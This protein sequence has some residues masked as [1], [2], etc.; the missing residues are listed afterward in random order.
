VWYGIKQLGLKDV[1][2]RDKFI[3]EKYIRASVQERRDLLSA[4]L[5]CDGCTNGGHTTYSTMSENLAENVIELVQS[6]GGTA[7]KSRSNRDGCLTV[8]IAMPENPFSLPRKADLWDS[9]SHRAPSRRIQSIIPEGEAE[10]VCIQVEAEDH[11]YVTEDYIVTHYDRLLELIKPDFVH[12]LHNGKIAK[13]GDYTLALEL[14]EKGFE[15]IGIK[16]ENR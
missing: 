1:K 9:V 5:D 15:G 12:I 7:S 11:L 13:T 2:S 14:D 8:A 3:P 4:L 10:V 6:L 16:D